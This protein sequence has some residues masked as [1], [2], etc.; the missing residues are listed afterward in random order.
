MKGYFLTSFIMSASLASQMP[1][2]DRQSLETE[3]ANWEASPKGQKGLQYMRQLGYS[4][5]S[6]DEKLSR[7]NA[8]YNAVAE[9]NKQQ[10]AATF[11]FSNAFAL[12]ND[13]DFSKFIRN[14]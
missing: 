2:L 12:M 1:V 5:L 4:N 10:P 8:T 7:F 9:L 13:A 11:T 3:L 6:H 14:K